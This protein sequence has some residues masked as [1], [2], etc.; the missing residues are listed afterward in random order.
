MAARHHHRLNM[1]KVNATMAAL[2]AYNKAHHTC[3]S[4]GK[5]VALQE[6]GGVHDP[7]V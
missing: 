2:E 4:Y 7:A 3:L 5:F 1:Q 6:R